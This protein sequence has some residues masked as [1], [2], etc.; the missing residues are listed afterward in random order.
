M[1][2]IHYYDL[3]KNSKIGIWK[4]TEMENE[5]IERTRLL[6]LDIDFSVLATRKSR[7]EFCITQLLLNEMCARNQILFEGIT[8]N[9][10][11]KPFLKQKNAHISYAHSKNYVAAILNFEYSVG[12]DIEFEQEKLQ[13]IKS[14]FLSEKEQTCFET[15]S[16]LCQAWTAKEAAYK[17]NGTKGVSLKNDIKIVK[18]N[19][20]SLKGEVFDWEYF[21]IEPLLWLS[22]VIKT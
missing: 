21:N 22:Y 4:A 15:L 2:F 19:Q 20:I 3:Q 11:G 1:P 13:T 18:P 14:K 9:A 10:D 17:L 16:E 5:W 7:F 6:H 8:K 12:L